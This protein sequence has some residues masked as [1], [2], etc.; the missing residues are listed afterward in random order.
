MYVHPRA[1]TDMQQQQQQ[2]QPFRPYRM[3]VY[4]I[5]NF[6]GKRWQAFSSCFGYF[7]QEVSGKSEVRPIVTLQ[8]SKTTAGSLHYR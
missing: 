7:S 4:F 1:S 3:Q 6:D 5:V 8:R 2:Q